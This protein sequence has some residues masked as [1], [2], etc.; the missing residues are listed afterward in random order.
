MLQANVEALV[1]TVNT[2]GV[3]GKGIALQF[4]ERFPENYKLYKKAAEEKKL[5]TGKVLIIPTNRMD[6]VKWIINFPTKKHWRNPSK[7]EYI[8]SGLDDLVKVINEYQIKS[9]AVPPL[10]CGNGGLDWKEIKPIIERKLSKLN[11][12]DIQVYE[13]S[14]IAYEQKEKKI[15]SKPKLTPTRAIIIYLMKVYSQFEY[16]L[17]LLETQKLVYFLSRLGDENA[18]KIKFEKFQYGPYAYQLAHIL[19]D[20]D[21]VYISGMKYKDVKTFDPLYIIE[22]NFREI[23]EFITSNSTDT[24]KNRLENLLSLIEGFETPLSMEVLATVDYVLYNEVENKENLDEIVK[25]VHDWNNHKKQ[26]LTTEYIKVA[27]E[28]LKKFSKVLNYY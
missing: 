26:V 24:Q 17:T 14:D 4:K 7:L 15:I 3:M 23:D 20:I 12:V 5:E 22:E 1:N 18:Q 27:H 21:G 9:I 2:V 13:P 11:D 19:Y 6:D 8:T 10:G 28:R 16:S 25:K